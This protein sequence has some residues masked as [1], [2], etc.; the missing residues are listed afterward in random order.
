MASLGSL[1][2]NK[3][4]DCIQGFV[5]S[6]VLVHRANRR[7]LIELRP[8]N[9]MIKQIQTWLLGRGGSRYTLIFRSDVV[10]CKKNYEIFRMNISPLEK[11]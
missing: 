6:G 8:N 10:G 7:L 1:H 11:N 3:N 2:K 5:H 9:L 4:K